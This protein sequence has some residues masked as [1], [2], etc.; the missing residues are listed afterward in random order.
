M[1]GCKDTIYKIIPQILFRNFY[2]V[3]S[4]SQCNFDYLQI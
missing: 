4:T 1:K 3:D 2:W